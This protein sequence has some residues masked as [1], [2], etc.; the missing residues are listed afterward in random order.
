MKNTI[1]HGQIGS[2]FESCRSE[3]S[4]SDGAGEKGGVSL[5]QFGRWKQSPSD[6][7]IQV[8]SDVPFSTGGS[9][10][11]TPMNEAGAGIGVSGSAGT[12]AKGEGS[13]SSPFVAPWAL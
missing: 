9:Q 12:G 10:F 4:P 6:L 11:E 3:V 13:L 2:P 8:G 7:P 1:M 5:G